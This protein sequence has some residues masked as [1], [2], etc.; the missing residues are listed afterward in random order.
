MRQILAGAFVGGCLA[1]QTQA[2]ELV[3]FDSPACSY[4][5]QWDEEISGIYPLTDE[6]RRAP[7][8]RVSVHDEMPA[9]LARIGAVVYTPTFVLVDDGREVGRISGYPGED[10]F[11]GFLE[12]LIARLAMSSA[13]CDAY[14][15]SNSNQTG[16]KTL[17]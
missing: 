4:C 13:A 8:R 16:R 17:C 1:W 5:E 10:F 2:A 12:S 9:D 7:L 6:G 14:E 3:M 11:W 15:N